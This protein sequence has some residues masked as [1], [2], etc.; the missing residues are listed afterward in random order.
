MCMFSRIEPRPTA[1]DPAPEELTDK[2]ADAGNHTVDGTLRDAARDVLA[3]EGGGPLSLPRSAEADG[4]PAIEAA[5]LAH[6][7][8]RI[9]TG[10]PREVFAKG[11][12]GGT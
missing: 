10:D 3:G 9:R 7:S 6:A 12:G 11:G 5:A 8:R 2:L 1:F 4:R